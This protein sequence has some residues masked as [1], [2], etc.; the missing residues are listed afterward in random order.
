[1]CVATS[2]GTGA[3]I[4]GSTSC[5][6]PSCKTSS[7]CG[8]DQVCAINTCC[9]SGGGICIMQSNVCPNEGAT[10]RMFRRRTW[11]GETVGGGI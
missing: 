6:N 5:A 3:C 2:E 11:D 10:S 1:L 4:S 9:R 8:A 7:D